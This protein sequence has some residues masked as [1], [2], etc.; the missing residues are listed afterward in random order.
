MELQAL[1]KYYDIDGDGS[2]SYEEFLRGLRDELTERRQRMV[3]KAFA[4]MDKD[5][6]G[7]LNLADV[8]KLPS[9]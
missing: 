1:M 3:N 8:S 6:S 4:I 2:V 5:G 9:F 7:Q